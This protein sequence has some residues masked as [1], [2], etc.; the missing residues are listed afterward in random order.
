MALPLSGTHS[1]IIMVVF[2]SILDTVLMATNS[3]SMSDDIVCM[4]LA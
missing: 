4:P 2:A 1:I 3:L